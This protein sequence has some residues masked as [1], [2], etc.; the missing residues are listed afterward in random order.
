[1]ATSCDYCTKPITGNVSQMSGF[2][3]PDDGAEPLTAD[4]VA[5]G[6]V[7]LDFHPACGREWFGKAQ[8]LRPG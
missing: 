8:E 3:A 7:R 2:L 4:N 1:M 5:D 6:V